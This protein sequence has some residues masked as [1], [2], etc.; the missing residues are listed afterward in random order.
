M[1]GVGRTTA[2]DSLVEYELVL[3]RRAGDRLLYEAHPSGQPSATFAAG[4]T[5]DSMVVF[6]NPA[7]DFPQRVGYRRLSGDSLG[8]WIEGTVGG[9][10]RRIDFPYRRSRCAGE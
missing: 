8:A 3:V 10:V 4:E 5:S 7:H 1:V 9:H 2:G 6:E